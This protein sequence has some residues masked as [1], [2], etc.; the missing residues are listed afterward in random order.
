MLRDEPKKLTE[1]KERFEKAKINRARWNH[2][3]TEASRYIRP[4]APQSGTGTRSAAGQE[5]YAH[6]FD[7]TAPWALAQFSAGLHSNVSSPVDRWF[8]LGVI[9]KDKAQL[10]REEIL[11]LEDTADRLYQEYSMP[12]AN[13]NS[14]LH[15]GYQDL[16]AF[17]SCC[18]YQYDTGNHVGFRAFPLASTFFLENEECIIDQCFVV[19]EMTL[20]QIS[21]RFPDAVEKDES[22][23]KDLKFDPEMRKEVVHAVF[24]RNERDYEAFRSAAQNKPYASV[25]FSPAYTFVLGESGYDEFP[26]HISRWTKGSGETYGRGPSDPALPDIRMVNA[27]SRELLFSAQLANRPPIHVSDESL[28]F[29]L[30]SLN[31]GSIIYG[32]PGSESKPEPILSGSQPQLT[33]ELMEQRREVI[34]SAFFVDYLIRPKKKERQTQVEIMDDRS[35]MFRQMAPNIGR[36]QSELFTTILRR[37]FRLMA[38]RRALRPPPMSLRGSPIIPTYISPAASAQYGMKTAAVTQFIQDLAAYGNIDPTIFQGIDPDA[39]R[40][41][42]AKLRNVTLRILKDPAQLRREREEQQEMVQQQL[43]S[44]QQLEASSAMKNVAQSRQAE[45]QI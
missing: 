6:L 43:Q 7:A 23:A 13:F 29:P 18:I 44:Q 5:S 19:E 17:G 8:E 3:F 40:N 28:L 27:M 33:L 36:L 11:W 25:F 10:E 21:L 37:T 22:F 1:L 26:Y 15:E 24:P 12:E 41:E 16:G 30:K 38:R 39:L 14:A 9:G 2:L 32:V 35:E 20:R 42:L 4:E 31:P 34:R 45:A